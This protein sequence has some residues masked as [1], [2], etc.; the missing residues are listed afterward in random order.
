MSKPLISHLQSFCLTL[1]LTTASRYANGTCCSDDQ[2]KRVVLTLGTCAVRVD[3]LFFK[4]V[5]VDFL[6]FKPVRV[7]F[8]FFKPLKRLVC[9][10]RA[11]G[12]VVYFFGGGWVGER[13]EG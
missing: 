10:G 1:P 2:P 4:P 3:F 7:D 8:L 5:R 6:F 11:E 9:V 12:M 13:R